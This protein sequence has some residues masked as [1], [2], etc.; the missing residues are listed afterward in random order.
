MISRAGADN[1]VMRA[2]GLDP[3]GMKRFLL[4][5]VSLSFG[6]LSLL[7]FVLVVIGLFRL[8]GAKKTDKEAK[9]KGLRM[10]LFTL[11]PFVLI[12]FLWF[13]LYNFI[14]KVSI[15][16]EQV[17]AEI[18]VVQPEDLEN[19]QAPIEITLSALNVAKALEMGGFQIESMSWDLEGDGTFETAVTTNPEV[20]HIYNKKG[21]YNV[22]L[23]VKITGE[24]TS[25][26]PYVKIINIPTAVFAT[27]PSTGVP[28]LVVQFD[29]SDLIT[30]G[31]KVKSLDWDFDGDGK[32]DVEGPDNQ[33][34]RHTFEQIGTFNVH[35]RIIDEQNNVENY[36]KD[37]EIAESTVPLVS[38]VISAT[39]GLSGPIPF[40]VRFDAGESESLKGT[41]INYEWDFG[42]G[43]DIQTGKSVSH[44]F[45][46]P[47]VYTVTLNVTDDLGMKSSSNVQVDVKPVSSPPEAALT[48]DPAY[49]TAT[50][51]LSGVLPFNVSFDASSSIDADNDI[52]DYKWDFNGDGQI[53][54]EGVKASYIFEEAKNY[55]MT[56]TVT[57]SEN[58]SSDVSITVSV[59]TPGVQAVISANPEEGTVPLIV[60]FDGSGS[61]AYEGK[62]VSYE[63]DFGDGSP[64]T[65]TSATV[66]H[67]YSAVGN[68]TVKLKVVTN[69]SETAEGSQIIYVREIPLRACFTPSRYNGGAPLAVTFDTKCSTGGISKFTWDFGDEGV[70]DDRKP[71]HT[72]EFPG[73]Y[74]VT[75]EVA[76]DK[77]NVSTYSEVIVAEGDVTE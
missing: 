3:A 67:K 45:Q 2:F 55:Q 28:P 70:S 53:D 48:T 40:Q 17:V 36:Y 65:I 37:I 59:S 32:Y 6:T 64:K 39:P 71:T 56:L 4:T 8:L 27:E 50:M 13:G 47:G 75:L 72:F 10:T 52:V 38:G 68:Y 60:N 62:I 1:P 7:F 16:A 61:S 76:D 34:P 31:I 35:L 41:I 9:N 66:S 29:A 11:I 30:K 25:R 12:V 24:E 46:T 23:Q 43:S 21:I 26:P 49:D 77:S 42:D 54:Q 63:W 19:L 74:T 33:R 51:R 22:A 57:D 5:I 14:N 44:I 69:K 15:A 20:S 73:A 58:Q 18:V